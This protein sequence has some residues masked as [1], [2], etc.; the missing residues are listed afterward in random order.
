MILL[1]VQHIWILL[2]THQSSHVS[3][4]LSK[5]W[6]PFPVSK[7]PLTHGPESRAHAVSRTMIPES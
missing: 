3:L 5:K 2:S 1:F 4:P 7:I 6:I